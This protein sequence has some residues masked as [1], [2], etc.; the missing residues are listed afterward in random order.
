MRNKII[1]LALL[2]I[3]PQL[4]YGQTGEVTKVGSTAANFL[5][6]E[7]GARAIAL[8]GAFT[9]VANDGSSM[10]WN[11]AGMA[12]SDHIMVYYNRVNLYADMSHD[13]M[14]VIVPA[15][16]NYF[17]VAFNYLNIGTMEKT[18]IDEPEGTDIFFTS[19]SM[20]ISL[21]YA[22]MLTDRITFGV[23]GRYIHEQIWQEKADGMS[24]DLGILFTPGLSGLRL[25]MSITNLG[26]SI[27]MDDG[28][29]QTFYRIPTEG[30]EGTG[31][32]N[33]P[34]KYMVDSYPMPTSF[35]LGAVF[36]VMGLNSSIIKNTANRVSFVMEVNDAFDNAM[37]SKFGLEYEWNKI[38]ALRGGYKQN[39]D[40]ASYT[41]GAG[42]K[43]PYEG[44]DLRFD[45]AYA[46]YGDLGNV[47]ITSIQIGF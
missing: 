13:F 10:Y 46:D 15:G 2:I 32:R 6:L 11:P 35:Q 7:V 43:I 5:G 19:S 30:Q 41:F 17:G 45:Y 20:A 27:A 21:S 24:A 34:A 1:L 25:G 12:Y 4:V 9:A 16:A 38:L 36:D 37:R 31:N 14:G 22:R 3:S 39:Y 44:V 28:P 33:M 8:A 29:L 18:T 26:P 40:L 42:L 23:S 47:Q